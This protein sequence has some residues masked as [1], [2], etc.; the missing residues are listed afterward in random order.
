M[1][2]NCTAHG[3]EIVIWPGH[4]K[5]ISRMLSSNVIGNKMPKYWH[6][7]GCVAL[8]L[9]LDQTG[10]FALLKIILEIHYLPCGVVMTFISFVI[11]E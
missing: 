5:T 7:A 11:I 3:G 1:V 4:Q 2:Q 10:R 8:P 6:Y 9:A